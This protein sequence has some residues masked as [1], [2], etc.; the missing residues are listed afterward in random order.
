MRKTVYMISGPA[1]AGKSTTSRKIAEKL[2][3]S[4]YIEGDII[5]HMV[6]GG[7]EKPWLSESHLSLIWLNILTITKNFLN[8]YH[9]VIIDYVTYY[10]KTN[11]M[12]EGL[13]D[14][15]IDIKFIV[16]LVD[17]EALLRRDRERP[18][19]DQMGERCIIGLNEILESNPPR[20]HILNTTYIEVVD[21]VDDI[22]NNKKYL[23]T[24]L[25]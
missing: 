3:K 22:L 18:V 25:L 17:Q 16:L 24:P 13:R 8:N 4:A 5:N 15:D 10:D 23:L 20:N 19:E 1:G 7:H 14:F 21:V 11:Y 9:D 2:Q 6:I 12:L